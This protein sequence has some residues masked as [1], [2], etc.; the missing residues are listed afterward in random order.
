MLFPANTQLERPLGKGAEGRRQAGVPATI[1]SS[2]DPGTKAL[3]L[4]LHVG[5]RGRR[6]CPQYDLQRP[7]EKGTWPVPAQN[8]PIWEGVQSFCSFLRWD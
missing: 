5:R 6:A 2:L 7:P 3:A 1:Q 4:G 8:L